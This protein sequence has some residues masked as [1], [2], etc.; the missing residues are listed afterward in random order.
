M[1]TKIKNTGTPVATVELPSGHVIK[2]YKQGFLEHPDD[3][4]KYVA[5]EYIASGS[6]KGWYIH[7]MACPSGLQ[8]NQ[9]KEICDYPSNINEN[10][11]TPVVTQELPNGHVIKCYKQG[12]LEHP[13]DKNKFVACEYIASGSNKGWYIHI[14]SCAPGTQWNQ[15]LEI[16]IL[17][18]SNINENTGTPVAT[19]ELP[20]GHVIK[21]Y[22]QGFLEHP[23]DKNKFVTCEYIASGSNKGWH[24]NIMACPSGLQW[25][26]NKG[27]CDYP[28]A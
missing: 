14:M 3:K 10:T 2:C 9:N 27:V 18:Q 7:I 16:C 1:T 23:D 28:S 13:D 12:F 26:Q 8:W 15:K 25:N 22:K 24:I 20:S 11:G 19:E 17:D 4:N 21:C 6:N 5:C